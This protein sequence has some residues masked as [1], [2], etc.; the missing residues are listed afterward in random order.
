MLDQL[1][2]AC[3]A[4]SPPRLAMA[5]TDRQILAALADSMATFGETGLTEGERRAVETGCSPTIGMGS[6]KVTKAGMLLSLADAVGAL[7]CE[8]LQADVRN[9]EMGRVESRPHKSEVQAALEIQ[10]LLEG[11]HNVNSAAKGPA[12]RDIAALAQINGRLREAHASARTAIRVELNTGMAGEV[13]SEDA[14]QYAPSFAVASSLSSLAQSAFSCGSASCRRA[15]TMSELLTGGDGPLSAMMASEMEE[16]RMRRSAAKEAASRVAGEMATAEVDEDR[17]PGPLVASE[18]SVVLDFLQRAL[19]LEALCACALLRERDAG[20]KEG[21]GKKAQVNSLGK[22]TKELR[23][24]LD[25][26]LW[27]RDECGEPS[28]GEVVSRLDPRNPELQ[29]QMEALRKVIEANAG[30]RKPKLPKGTRDFM[31]EQMAIRQKAF[32]KITEIFKRHGAVEL[33]TPVFELRETL[34]GKYGEDSKLI[35]DLA[36]QGGELLSLR[37]DLTVPF[38]RFLA[39]HNVTNIKRYHIAKVYRRDNPQ[40]SKGRFREFYQCDFDIA[41]SYPPMVADSEAIQVFVEILREL[42]MGSFKVKLNHRQ[43]L[44]AALE[45]SGAPASKFRT[46]SSSIDKL[47]KQ[48]WE[49]VCKELIDD[50]GLDASIVDSIHTFVTYHGPPK[51]LLETLK[52]WHGHLRLTCCVDASEAF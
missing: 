5:R 52:V 48:P 49:E 15:E 10:A 39:M 3:N 17:I 21:G 34:M 18:S 28:V 6:L 50:K 16:C 32:N 24:W 25:S 20:A 9:L 36:D 8:A 4:K 11:S 40:V 33:D 1:K 44:D 13:S 37:F 7:A 38:A 27:L 45:I 35:Y 47:D 46:I 31:P 29:G 41:G 19:A 42:E 23:E 14:A 2:A 22:G 12:P 43:L 26:L 51:K 30:R